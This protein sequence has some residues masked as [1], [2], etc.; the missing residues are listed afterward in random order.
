MRNKGMTKIILIVGLSLSMALPG[1]AASPEFARTAEEWALLRD[2]VL[3]FE[4][5]PDLIEEYNAT[6]LANEAAYNSD[7]MKLKNAQQ[8]NDALVSMA[9]D[10]ESMATDAEGTTGGAITAASYRMMADQLRSQAEGNT[11]D[12]EIVRLE[13]E[14]QKLEIIKNAKDLYVGYYKQQV[15]NAQGVKDTEYL[16]R[17]HASAVNRKNAGMAT[18][19][20]VLSALENLQKAQAAAITNDV[21]LSEDY[22]K[23]IT[24]C[25]WKYDSAAVLAGAPAYDPATVAVVEEEQCAAL[26]LE[27][28]ITLRSD[29]RRL[30]NARSYYGG[31]AEDKAEKQLLADQN[32]VKSNYNAA[33]NTLMLAKA[34]YDN[35]VIS[36]QV[37]AGNLALSARQLNLGVISKM[38]YMTAEYA[39]DQSV[40]AKETAWYDL[41][42]ARVAF[43]AVINGLA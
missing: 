30:E 26:A 35:A 40:S 14:R 13:Y 34:T 10:Y 29:K 5:I 17:A 24:L 31:E 37:K 32:T 38:E 2:N 11:S 22:K 16:T 41:I 25:G 21:L 4:E 28:S 18:E 6:V 19:L 43:D 42:L 15:L 23:L 33:Y 27:N 20:D 9:D 12:Y 8:T 3:S 7:D 39:Y 1:L 36:S